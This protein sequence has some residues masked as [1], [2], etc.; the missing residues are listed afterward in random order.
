MPYA[1]TQVADTPNRDVQVIDMMRGTAAWNAIHA[2]NQYNEAAPAGM[3]YL[4]VKIHVKSKYADSNRHIIRMADFEVTGEKLI[5]YAYAGVVLPNPELYA[6]L[7][8]DGETEG[9]V[10]FLVGIG[11]NKLILI[12]DEFLN[13][14][15]SKKRF[16]ALDSGASISVDP[17]L[18]NI[19]PTN[20]GILRTSPAP[21]FQ[22]VIIDNWE[23]TI[24]QTLRGNAAWQQ[25]IAT[26]QFNNPPAAGMEYILA[27]IRVR[28]IGTL[29]EPVSTNRLY[30]QTTGSANVVYN[31]P[32]I[33]TPYPS[34]DA[35]LYP[36]GEYEGMITVQVGQGETGVMLIVKPLF[37]STG[38]NTRF[39][40]L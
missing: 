2:A 1:I 25:I 23:V 4:L 13:S 24:S 28:Y 5:A 34:L 36:G 6:E 10:A 12:A 39:L 38:I 26:N 29:D 20:I 14:D 27:T 21:L 40:L 11:E 33:V 9:W 22:K 15:E 7:F 8:T 32:P 3:E 16:I 18:Q 31:A 37:D 19:S 35:Y 30:F 17:A